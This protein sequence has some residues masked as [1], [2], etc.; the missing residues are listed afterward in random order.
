MGERLKFYFI[1]I[2][3]IPSPNPTANIDSAFQIPIT[4]LGRVPAEGP[5]RGKGGWGYFNL[6]NILSA[7]SYATL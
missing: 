1:N 2:E 3:D 4:D 5:R 7:S 6:S